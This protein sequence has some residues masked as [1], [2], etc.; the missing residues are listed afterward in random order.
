MLRFLSITNLAVIEYAEIEFGPGLNVMT[1]ETGA[2]KSMLVEAIA[3]LLGGRASA[4]IVRTGA[5]QM[6]VQAAIDG[7]DGSELLV[8]REV[9]AQGRSRAFIN[10]VLV[11]A[12]A[13]KEAI[14]PLVELH[15]QHEH[16]ALLAPGSH[17]DLLDAYAEL[18][19]E[20]EA[21]ARAF[22][23]LQALRAALE[24]TELDE[25][26][27]AAR[28]DLVAFQ[29]GEL[30]RAGLKAGED[31][32]LT[33]ERL[34][35]AN[36]DKVERLCR[37]GYGLLYESDQAALGAL[38]QAWKRVTELAELDPVFRP[39]LE[40]RDTIKAHLEELAHLLRSY[41]DDVAASPARLQHVDER[42]AVIERLKRKYGPRLEDVIVRQNELAQELD[43]LRHSGERVAALQV[44]AQEAQSRYAE[45]C[46][47]LGRS[48]RAAA[49][50]FSRGLERNLAEL[51]MERTRFAV[52]F[53]DLTESPREWSSRGTD[54]VEFYVSPNPGEELRPLARTASGGE[55]S[56]VMLALKT[57]VAA[58]RGGT[59][60]IFD[61]VDA[62]IGGRVADVVG[63]RLRRLAEDFQVLCI[64]H[65]P[66]LAAHAT[67]HFHID[68]RVT[69]GRTLTSV[70]LLSEAA[71]IEELAR[72]AGVTGRSDAARTSAQELIEA[73]RA[74]HARPGSEDKSKGERAKAKERK[75]RAG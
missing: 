26:E 4:D 45:V 61:E 68:K 30:E 18:N 65:L 49:D 41:A 75:R 52:R 1:G 7:L 14:L 60:M 11:S 50:G 22:D 31:D 25:R 51:A 3:L 57:L 56:R 19:P 63:A 24:T 62:G 47:T 53:S 43:G 74:Q 64:T 15:G 54:G 37:E 71:R 73:A 27:R 38:A 48:R 5:D 10:G 13:L 9:S 70:A 59:T 8:R 46:E 23:E 36:A 58:R 66:Q 29:L 2:G 40:S 17:V 42:M 21:V 28:I 6:Q 16:Q 35:L 39:H 20:R 32:A 55:L 72:M 67:T 12:A 34:V 69:D 33:A 44:R